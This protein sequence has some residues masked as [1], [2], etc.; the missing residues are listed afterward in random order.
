MPNNYQILGINPSAS[1]EEINKAHRTLLFKYHPDHNKNEEA[2]SKS[3]E[4]NAA[5]DEIMN[6]KSSKDPQIKKEPPAPKYQNPSDFKTTDDI[7][8]YLNSGRRIDEKTPPSGDTLLILAIRSKRLDFIEFLLLNDAQVNQANFAKNTP[9]ME[10]SLN[11]DLEFAYNAA[12]LLMDK[13]AKLDLKTGS[14][15][16]AL[17]MAA[18][19]KNLRL[20]EELFSR[21]ADFNIV[22]TNFKTAKDFAIKA[23]A[24]D[25]IIDF[26]NEVSEKEIDHLL[27]KGKI[28][29]ALDIMQEISEYQL[30]L[31]FSFPKTNI[32]EANKLGTTLLML[33]AKTANLHY[34][35]FLLEKGSDV[36]PE[37]SSGNTA[38]F[39][40]S[41]SDDLDYALKAVELLIHYGAK[42]NI[43]NKKGQTAIAKAIYY[44]NIELVILLL[45]NQTDID[46][47]SKGELIIAKYYV[48]QY[49]TS[50]DLLSKIEDKLSDALADIQIAIG[51]VDISKIG[52][53]LSEKMSGIL[54]KPAPINQLS[55][56]VEN[57]KCVIGD[58]Y[59]SNIK[60]GVAELIGEIDIYHP[61]MQLRWATAITSTIAIAENSVNNEGEIDGSAPSNILVD[62][63]LR[64]EAKFANLESLTVPSNTLSDAIADLQSAISND[65]I[66]NVGASLSG[67][68]SHLGRKFPED[69]TNIES[70]ID[71]TTVNNAVVSSDTLAYIQATF[72]SDQISKVGLTVLAAIGNIQCGSDTGISLATDLVL[73]SCDS[74][75]SVVSIIYTVPSNTIANTVTGQIACTQWANSGEDLYLSQGDQLCSG[76][77]TLDEGLAR[78]FYYLEAHS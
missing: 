7:K 1:I 39:I 64:I 35:Q 76:I 6:S 57:I 47:L 50:Q 56:A 3:Q 13:G 43:V 19:S 41:D 73:N 42:V 4:I 74:G 18:N 66:G 38:L 29:E 68:F 67:T 59:V 53:S 26:F 40:A 21:G 17:M 60:P 78:C 24:G 58:D 54:S 65:D 36:N 61:E 22:S 33:A 72:S 37:D 46:Y 31:L 34:V 55:Y 15:C 27:S 77:L 2:V 23:E 12:I 44:K 30:D 52:D 14:G 10:A 75:G 63:L 51:T 8:E 16:T 49:G 11:K 45:K 25:N 20:I 71:E 28:S 48:E 5:F 62:A 32:N 70:L 9:L 69:F